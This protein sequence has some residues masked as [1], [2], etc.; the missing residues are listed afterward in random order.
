MVHPTAYRPRHLFDSCRPLRF[1]CP[2]A[3]RWPALGAFLPARRPTIGLPPPAKCGQV[4][5]DSNPATAMP[6]ALK[7]TARPDGTLVTI[8]Y[9]GHVTAELLRA[10]VIEADALAA[11]A[12]PGF[13]FLTDLTGLERMEVDCAPILSQMMV[14]LSSFGVGRIVRVIPDP[15]KDIG[16]GILSLFHLKSGVPVNTVASRAEAARLIR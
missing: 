16:L 1:S 11:K 6:D 4:A 9:S 8:E 14:R 7:I 15:K 12:K 13:T 10:H 3:F 2:L 5:S